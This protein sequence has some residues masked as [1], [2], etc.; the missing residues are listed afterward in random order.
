MTM[1]KGACKEYDYSTESLSFF[2]IR[3]KA[4]WE[5]AASK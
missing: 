2:V 3:D 4:A 1:T 5:T